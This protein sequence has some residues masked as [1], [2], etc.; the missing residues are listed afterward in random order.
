MLP[1][2]IPVLYFDKSLL[3]FVNQFHSNILDKTVEI[4]SNIGEYAII[5]I[6]IAITLAILDKKNAKRFLLT[7]AIALIA[8]LLLNDGIIKHLFFRER[9]YLALINIYHVGLN[10]SNSSFVSGH[11]AS[12]VASLIVI[13]SYYKK[14]IA[15]C[16]IITLIMIYTRFYLGMHYPTD[17]LGGIVVGALAGYSAVSLIKRAKKKV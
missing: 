2:N 13:G 6:I 7:L 15:P 1:I 14:M 3:L 8:E 9:P 4:I 17:I 16:A 10:W 5:W 11:T 12:S